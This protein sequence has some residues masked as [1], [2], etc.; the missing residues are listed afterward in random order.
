MKKIYIICTII[1]IFTAGITLTAC[2]TPQATESEK[3]GV[4]VSIL[5]QKYFVERIGGD[6][7][8]VNVMVG[9]G[10]DPHTYEP[11]PAQ[12]QALSTSQIYFTIGVEFEDAWLE[13]FKDTNPELKIIDTSANVEKITMIAEE[14]HEEGNEEDHE[15]GEMDPHI[16]LSPANVRMIAQSIA[17]TLS[18]ADPQ[19]SAT[20]QNNLA[21]FL[22]DIDSL[23]E[24]IRASLSPLSTRKFITFH[25]AWGYFARDYNLEQISIE[26]EGNEPSA[27]EMANL[28]SFAK[29][30]DIHF[31]F[32]EP[33]FNTKSAETIAAE[34]DGQVILISPLAEDWL[35]NLK[36]VA[37]SIASALQ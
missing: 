31:I 27:T 4:T 20:Y 2:S 15:H 16:W 22:Q 19:N 32:A 36:S 14:N 13:K 17:T 5:P 23:D 12:M 25:P 30:H 35:G 9:P 21:A 34:I 29:A 26:V 1:C 7:V 24:E 6:L 8:T 33:E 11:Q 10:E 28:I 3:I 37:Q 18:E